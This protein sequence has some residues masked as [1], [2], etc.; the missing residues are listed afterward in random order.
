MNSND[1]FPRVKIKVKAR[2]FFRLWITERHY[3]DFQQKT[4]IIQ[5]IFE[6]TQ[7]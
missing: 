6:K 3:K 2:I 7:S 5:K 1:Y 4:K